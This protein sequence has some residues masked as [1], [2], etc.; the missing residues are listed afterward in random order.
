MHENQALGKLSKRQIPKAPFLVQWVWGQ[1]VETLH[2]FSAVVPGTPPNPV[3]TN[4]PIHMLKSQLPE[5]LVLV[6][7]DV[8][9]QLGHEVQ[10]P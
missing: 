2:L 5:M 10:P 4:S 7:G 6:G 3:P 9:K 8:G 1:S